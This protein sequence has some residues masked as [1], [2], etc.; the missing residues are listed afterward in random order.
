MKLS[1]KLA[2]L[3][4]SGSF[5]VTGMPGLFQRLSL[6]DLSASET[7]SGIDLLETLLLSLAGTVVA[8]FIGFQVGNILLHPKAKKN[9]RSPKQGKETTS[10]AKEE[11]LLTTEPLSEAFLPPQAPLQPPPDDESPSPG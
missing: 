3:F 5:I 8:G 2:G 7:L 9:T 10:L 4:A 6:T 1:M 11:D